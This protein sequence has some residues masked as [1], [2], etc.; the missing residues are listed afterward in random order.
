MNLFKERM[1]FTLKQMSIF[2]SAIVVGAII[3]IAFSLLLMTF[4]TIGFLLFKAILVVLST[5]AIAAI[6]LFINWLFI[7]PFR[8]KK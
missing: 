3:I 2:V 7:E 8:K 4:K 1:F 6:C 5:L